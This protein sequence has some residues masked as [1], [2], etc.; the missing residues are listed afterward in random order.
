MIASL[1]HR[2]RA[3]LRLA[4][5]LLRIGWPQCDGPQVAV[6]GSVVSLEP[7]AGFTPA[8]NFA[9]FVSEDGRA[10]ILVA[11]L[12]GDA[13]ALLSAAF[14]D[15][16]T[17]RERF[18]RQGVQVERLQSITSEG[19][20][21]PV[22]IGSQ[23]AHGCTFSKWV[24]LFGGAPTVMIT[25]QAP[26]GHALTPAQ[27]MQALSSVTRCPQATLAQRIAALPFSVTP[28][29]P[30][31]R[32]DTLSGSAVMLTAG[33]PDADAEV[34]R[35]LVIVA[36]EH[37]LPFHSNDLREMSDH[38]IAGSLRIRGGAIA[39]RE[40]VPFGGIS[41]HRVD[42]VAPDGHLYRQYL[43]LWPGERFVRLLAIFPADSSKDVHD[44]VD[45]MAASIRFHE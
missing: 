13:S 16:A 37:S 29:A 30:F 20:T 36:A 26:R 21:I 34:R 7:P 5:A 41:G 28:A 31:R 43:A 1:K 15:P 42:G 40:D 38:L 9:G 25:V 24:A 10:S 19:Q 32:V 2:A 4:P 3:V 14:A 35:P 18:S 6:P 12:P 17:A 11:E 44:A 45:A 23:V 39:S 33:E 22:V 27:A 8:P